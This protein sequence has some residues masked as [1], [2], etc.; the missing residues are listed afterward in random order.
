MAA[1]QT[2]HAPQSWHRWVVR[3]DTEA[4]ALFLC[5]RGY[6]LDPVLQGFPEL[7][8]GILPLGRQR[9]VLRIFIIEGR[10]LRA[11][12]YPHGGGPLPGTGHPVVPTDRNAGTRHVTELGDQLFDALI[13]GRAAQDHVSEVRVRSEAVLHGGDPET[14]RLDPL[15]HCHIVFVG[16]PRS[17]QGLAGAGNHVHP[18]SAVDDE[19]V[20]PEL[21]RQLKDFV[22][23]GHNRPAVP[24]SRPPVL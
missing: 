23:G 1:E 17:L 6:R 7:L 24:H 19:V 5:N 22:R 3:V 8:F 2:G 21:G 9:A 12:A 20:H 14:V 15:P 13:P 4:Y 18:W 10:R 11:C 16:R